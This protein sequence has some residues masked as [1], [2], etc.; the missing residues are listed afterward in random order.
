[1]SA[2]SRTT[3]FVKLQKTLK[4]IY[5]PVAL[6]ERSVLEHLLF[7]CC[8]EN[9]PP[10]KAEEAFAALVHT[11][12]DWN[13]IRVT[14]VK[15]LSEVMG[16]LPDPPLVANRIKRVLQNVFETTYKFDLED[17]RKKNLGV[18]VEKIEKINGTTKF[19]VAY[20]VQ[21][22]LGGHSIPV[23]SGTLDALRVVDL[24]SDEDHQKGVVPGLE[25]AI[26]KNKG[27]E[28]GSML[29]RLGA[30]FVA[31]PY[32]S[33]L[34]KIL[35]QINPEAEGRLPK[36]RPK[37][38]KP[39]TTLL[40]SKEPPSK[41]HE[42]KPDLKPKGR[43][44]AEA[45]A[46]A[47]APTSAPPPA[48]ETEKTKHKSAKK[49]AGPE[50]EK[51]AEVAPACEVPPASK[52]KPAAAKKSSG[53]EDGEEERPAAAKKTAVTTSAGLSKKKPR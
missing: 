32:A 27:A 40:E 11:F 22:A 24:I 30:D 28:F 3:Q 34:H 45:A 33:S 48:A 13:E 42:G 15:E 41:S 31:N 37:E 2:P 6:V 8:L 49:K 52:K 35:L 9:A 43:P 26:P 23:D 20:V 16:G 17:L 1:M 46:Q 39:E 36:R 44:P 47:A 25:R 50:P 5:E 7:A 29:H 4:K 14:T 53:A 51:S 21:A 19:S 38:H 10:E 18:A 12:F